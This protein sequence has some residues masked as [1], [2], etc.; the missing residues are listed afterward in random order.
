MSC[1]AH[2]RSAVIHWCASMRSTIIH[3]WAS[4]RAA[5][6]DKKKQIP[7]NDNSSMTHSV[8]CFLILKTNMTPLYRRDLQNICKSISFRRATTTKL[9]SWS[10][11]RSLHSQ[12][13]AIRMCPSTSSLQ[14]F[15]NSIVITVVTITTCS[16]NGGVNVYWSH[17]SLL[18]GSYSLVNSFALGRN[19][20][21]T[22]DHEAAGRLRLYFLLFQHATWPHSTHRVRPISSYRTHPTMN[23]KIVHQSVVPSFMPESAHSLIPTLDRV[24]QCPQWTRLKQMTRFQFHT[25]MGFHKG[26]VKGK[27]VS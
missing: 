25:Y 16:S 3:C 26:K 23:P 24:L 21:A 18:H 6:H 7:T 5:W 4:R 2:R 15:R 19:E 27:M 14:L 9:L 10:L 22:D 20:Q 1:C 13:V 12:F 11:T 17:R 8:T